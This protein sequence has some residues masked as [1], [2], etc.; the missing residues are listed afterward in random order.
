M[1]HMLLMISSEAP[2]ARRQSSQPVHRP[3]NWGARTVRANRR[4][5]RLLGASDASR[6]CCR[7]GLSA[8]VVAAG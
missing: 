7:S 8:R 4:S 5:G 2:P 3:E 6:G 1:Q